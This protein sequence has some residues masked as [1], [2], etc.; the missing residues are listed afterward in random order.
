MVEQQT[1][2]TQNV[3][4]SS[5]EGATPSVGTIPPE[6]PVDQGRLISDPGW[7]DSIRADEIR[8]NQIYT[9]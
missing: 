4:L 3:A 2:D 1:H 5:I 9:V 6:C 8:N 7:F